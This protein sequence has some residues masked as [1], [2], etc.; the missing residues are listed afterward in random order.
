MDEQYYRKPKQRFSVGALLMKLGKNKKLMLSLLISIP[1]AMFMLFSNRGIMKKISL[2]HDKEEMENKVHDAELEQQKLEAES[3]AL[4][5]DS[6]A[7]EKVAR[8]KYGLVR[9]GETVYKVRKEK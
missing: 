5:T 1:L 6:R 8:E 4:E 9:E 3:K 2:E 7:I